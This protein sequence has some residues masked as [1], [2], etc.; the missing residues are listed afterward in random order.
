VNIRIHKTRLDKAIKQK[1]LILFQYSC[2]DLFK[3]PIKITSFF[4]LDFFSDEEF[5]IEGDDKEF[6]TKLK[7]YFDNHKD[8]FF[9]LW[10]F[11]AHYSY[12]N[13]DVGLSESELS[14]LSGRTIDPDDVFALYATKNGYP[15]IEKIKPAFDT[16]YYFALLNNIEISDG[17]IWG[18][19][20]KDIKNYVALIKSS[21]VKTKIMAR[22]VSKYLDGTLKAGSNKAIIKKSKRILGFRG[23]LLYWRKY[24]KLAFVW[25]VLYLLARLIEFLINILANRFS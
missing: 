25:V 17:W 18:G 23:K 12:Q 20:E 22:L 7:K 2:T 6:R 24:W 14:D 5:S 21:R 10:N 13:L 9:A 3:K 11:N 8:Y 16:R 1:K 15:Y 4:A 19:N